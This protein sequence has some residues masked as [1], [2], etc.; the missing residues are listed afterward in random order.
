MHGIH[1]LSILH[2]CGVKLALIIVKQKKPFDLVAEWPN[3]QKDG[4]CRDKWQTPAQGARLAQFFGRLVREIYSICLQNQESDF[5]FL[6]L[7]L[8]ETAFNGVVF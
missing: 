8:K 5:W 7:D 2:E 1:I 3:P 6:Y 4:V